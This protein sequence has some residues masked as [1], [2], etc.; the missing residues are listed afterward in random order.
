[1]VK[2][3]IDDQQVEAEEGQ[4][5]LEVARKFHIHIPTL[6]FYRAI[7]PYGGCRVCLV[8]I[9][10][11]RGSRLVTSCSYPVAE[12]MYVR[13][14]SE[15]VLN[16]RKV[17]VD[18]LLARCPEV[19][20]IQELAA[21]LD[22]GPPDPEFR[23]DHDCIL[24]GLC[25]RVCVELMG[26]GAIGFHGRGAKRKVTTPYEEISDICIRCGACAFVCP[27]GARVLELEHITGR[28]PVPLLSEFDEGLRSRPS[29]YIPFPQAVPNKPVIDKDNCVRLQMGKCGACQFF[30]EAEAINYDMKDEFRD[31]KVGAIILSTGFKGFDA[32]RIF[33]LGYKRYPNVYTSLQIERMV[34][35]SG[36]TGG[37]I[38][39]RDGRQPKSVGIVHCVGSRD[40]K[41]NAYC[42]RVCCM[43]SLKLAHLIKERTG[44][45][46]YN[47]YI[48]MRTPGKGYEKF[49]E[50]LMRENVHF[51]RG[52]VAEVTDWAMTAE[53]E[54][55][56]VIRAE[57][58]LLGVVRRIPVDMVVLSIGMEPQSDSEGVRRKFN[59]SCSDEGWFLE[60]HPKLAPVST[61]TD[62]IF[63]AG[64]C[65]GP[66][67]IPDT[68]AQAGAA[69]AEVMALI[70][71]GHVDLEPNS[72]YIT[73][74]LCSGCKTC[75]PL[76]PFK[77]LSFNAEKGISAINEALCKGCGT[78][79]ASCPSGALQ[80][81]LFNDE[82]IYE[83]IKG[84]LS[85]V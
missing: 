80:Q 61:F 19:K 4:T 5:I 28:K 38:K 54:G 24:C 84:V 44:A 68:V 73:D 25:T 59:V 62:G 30:C 58:T 31:L 83:E 74:E 42:S 27:T 53:E 66:K 16:A 55:R 47:F 52:N 8:E 43:Y 37:E 51:I 9:A 60:R 1:M 81:N 72:A 21:E 49:Y 56:L 23:E 76:C 10:D 15:R 11:D 70:D 50:K 20:K 46:I 85:Y 3:F 71:K 33:R 26:V 7:S 45:E 77:A 82:Q 32:S 13:T 35:S 12:G 67:D 40:D 64:T 36:P 22:L 18:L 14:I 69:A 48:D 78:C 29:I 17:I 79:V 41:T 65:Q 34:N 39:L 75:I 57:D 63:I 6:C 2:L